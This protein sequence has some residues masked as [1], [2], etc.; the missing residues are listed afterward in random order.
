MSDT[1]RY[2]EMPGGVKELFPQLIIK[3]LRN[4]N[5]K[6]IPAELATISKVFF[7]TP[8]CMGYV[9]TTI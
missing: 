4:L 5:K 2:R 7:L 8:I 1:L 9:Q 6:Q 3:H